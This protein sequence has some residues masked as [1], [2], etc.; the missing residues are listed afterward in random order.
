MQQARTRQVGEPVEGS[1]D[2]AWGTMVQSS[3]VRYRFPNPRGDGKMVVSKVQSVFESVGDCPLA[4]FPTILKG[5]CL[6]CCGGCWL[7]GVGCWWSWK[8][9]RPTSRPT[10]T[11]HPPTPTSTHPR[12]TNR[13]G[14][15]FRPFNQDDVQP[16][17]TWVSI[18]TSDDQ[19]PASCR[20][21]ISML[22]SSRSDLFSPSKISPH[23]VEGHPKPCPAMTRLNWV[24]PL[25][26]QGKASLGAAS[27][28]QR[29][30]SSEHGRTTAVI[31]SLYEAQHANS[32]QA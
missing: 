4:H 13:H 9:S 15:T 32:L 7:S 3:T 2:G 19:L 27:K 24:R 16:T 28:T 25:T 14:G 10:P 31:L 22:F 18:K 20:S 5:E 21:S 17:R 30:K 11:W 1:S 29:K 26:A 8:S 12:P 23:R 6:D